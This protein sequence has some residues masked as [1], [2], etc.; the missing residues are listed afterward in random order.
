MVV[1]A[2]GVD[3]V[4]KQ[5]S[6]LSTSSSDQLVGS[7]KSIDVAV[8]SDVGKSS[9]GFE[10][11][12]RF[13]CH[14]SARVVRCCWLASFHEVGGP[15]AESSTALRSSGGMGDVG[16]PNM[17]GLQPQCQFRGRPPPPDR[18]AGLPA[19]EEALGRRQLPEESTGI[20]RLAKS[21]FVSS[22]LVFSA[23]LLFLSGPGIFGDLRSSVFG[24]FSS[25][26]GLLVFGLRKY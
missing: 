26:P 10:G 8:R 2:A 15:A 11:C 25:F 24:F 23:G 22:L 5:W 19:S 3:Q 4:S 1:A 9:S 21:R 7:A 6:V 13:G 20:C 18:L 12:P 14:C 17:P 16:G